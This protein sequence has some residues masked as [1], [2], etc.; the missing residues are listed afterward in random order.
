MGQRGRPNPR[1]AKLPLPPLAICQHV[2]RDHEGPITIMFDPRAYTTSK[3]LLQHYI[4]RRKS[5]YQI[6]QQLEYNLFTKLGYSLVELEF[7]KK[8]RVPDRP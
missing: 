7:R 6:A 1:S 8:C 5:H 3:P 2:E 4:R